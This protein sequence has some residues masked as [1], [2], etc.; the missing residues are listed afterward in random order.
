MKLRKKLFAV[1]EAILFLLPISATAWTAAGNRLTTQFAKDV[2]PN[3]PLPDYPRPHLVRDRWS[4]LN[5]IWSCS[6]TVLNATE[7]DRFPDQILVPFPI[8]SSLSGLGQRVGPDHLL[9]YRRTF[10]A[11]ELKAGERL[12]LNFGAVN[13]EA[14]VY[15]NG[16]LA[17]SHRGAYDS[18][19]FDISSLLKADS[20]QTLLVRVYAPANGPAP[21]G[22]QSLRP[23]QIFY[24]ASSG[25]WQTVWTEI[26]PKSHVTSL[27]IIPDINEACVYLTGQGTGDP[28]QSICAEVFDDQRKVVARQSGSARD[29][30][31]I[32]IPHVKLWSPDRP[33]LY[34]LRLTYG[35]DSVDSYFGMR[36]IALARDGNGVNRIFLN[37]K[38]CFMFGLLDQGYWPD[39]LY[40][41]PSDRAMRYDIEMT[42]AWGFNTIRKHMKVEPSRWYY[43][44]DKLGILVWQDF[45]AVTD[46]LVPENSEDVKRSP[47]VAGEIEGE[48]QAMVQNLVSHPCVIGWVPFNEG[49]GQFDTVRIANL[50]KTWDPTRLVDDASGW[51]DRGAGDVFDQHSYPHPAK[52]LQEK[53]R[54]SFQG[55]YGGGGLLVKDHDWNSSS[56]YQYAYFETSQDLLLFFTE[57]ANIIHLFKQSGLAGAIYTQTTDVENEI[58]GLMTYDR[59]PKIDPSNLKQV[60]IETISDP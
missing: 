16:Q 14:T 51:N 54:A 29:K 6:T 34:A 5:G 26:V 30:L 7:P 38:V 58:N 28:D 33:N 46:V 12:L 22:K 56:S 17:G 42:K 4:N 23:S 39:G 48:M 43:W 27:Q 57:Q 40:T 49:W 60:V 24:T 1:L 8:E 50:F 41:A 44:A 37:G 55:E 31:R 32:S 53:N 9:W 36:S 52:P 35:K 18:F 13:W 20:E 10:N 15:V 25:I 47:A 45:P 19:S 2:D 59:I 11:P 21:R 3:Q